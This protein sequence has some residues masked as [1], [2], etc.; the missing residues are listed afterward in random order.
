MHRQREAVSRR[1][2]EYRIFGNIKDAPQ[3]PT[4]FVWTRIE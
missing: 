4:R 3:L 2:D 1:V